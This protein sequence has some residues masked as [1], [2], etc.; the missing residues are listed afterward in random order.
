MTEDVI[1]YAKDGCQECERAEMLFT[2]ENRTYAKYV[3]GKDFTERQFVSEFGPNAEYP[4]IAIGCNHIGGLK[5]TLQHLY[6][7]RV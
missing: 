7:A 3:L 6:L 1:L 5:E 4:Q 2:S